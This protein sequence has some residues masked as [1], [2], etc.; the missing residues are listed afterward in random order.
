MSQ[1]V[2][3]G[4][5]GTFRRAVSPTGGFSLN[6]SVRQVWVLKELQERKFDY[7]DPHSLPIIR[8]LIVRGLVVQSQAGGHDI[9][10]PGR[11]ILEL[12]GA[13]PP[14]GESLKSAG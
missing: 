11:Q 12:L 9:T 7:L 4:T 13:E 6:L 10:E 2:V 14:E 3:E 8:A 1:T 5:W